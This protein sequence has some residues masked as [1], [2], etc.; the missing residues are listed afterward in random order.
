VEATSLII[1]LEQA[2]AQSTSEANTVKQSGNMLR[3]KHFLSES[4]IKVEET[5]EVG[6][7]DNRNPSRQMS[8]SHQSDTMTYEISLPKH[9]LNQL[10]CDYHEKRKDPLLKGEASIDRFIEEFE[11]EMKVTDINEK[12][13]EKRKEEAIFNNMLSV[14]TKIAGPCPSQALLQ[15]SH[16]QKVGSA[17]DDMLYEGSPQNSECL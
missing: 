2:T 8:M 4:I 7:M 15:I 9:P 16:F 11:R 3:L 10:I 1:P 13:Q 17:C 14:N 5:E 12:N 6:S